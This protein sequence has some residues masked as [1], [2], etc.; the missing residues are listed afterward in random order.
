MKTKKHK[1]LFAIQ[2][3][4]GVMIYLKINFKVMFLKFY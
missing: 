1:Q 2:F 4:E 3:F